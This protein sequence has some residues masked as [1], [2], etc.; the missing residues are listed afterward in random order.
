MW[1]QSGQSS[2]LSLTNKKLSCHLPE[3]ELFEFSHH[4]TWATKGPNCPGCISFF[5]VLCLIRTVT[6]RQLSKILFQTKQ[7]VEELP[8]LAP[9]PLPLPVLC[10]RPWGGSAATW[11]T[12]QLTRISLWHFL[13]IRSLHWVHLKPWRPRPQIRSWQYAQNAR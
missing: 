13:W 3:S 10:C 7:K 8:A 9:L 11:V 1:L 6:I 4:K 2:D 5:S 12:S